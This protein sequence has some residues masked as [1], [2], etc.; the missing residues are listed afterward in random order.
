MS[1]FF[2]DLRFRRS[3]ACIQM[4]PPMFWFLLQVLLSLKKRIKLEE[5]PF[6]VF[7]LDQLGIDAKVR[8]YDLSATT[9]IRQVSMKSLEFKG[10]AAH[11]T[12]FCGFTGINA[13]TEKLQRIVVLLIFWFQTLLVIRCVSSAPRL[14][15][16]PSFS[17][18]SSGR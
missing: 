10:Q 1:S 15:L 7:Q 12:G 5:A 6:L 9:Y 8:K 16:E 2:S 11:G 13:G 18:W 3:F 4:F 14:R 17:K